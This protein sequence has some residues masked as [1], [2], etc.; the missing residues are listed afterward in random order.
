MNG[1][2]FNDVALR[3][4]LKMTA[5]DVLLAYAVI[6]QKSIGRFGVGPVDASQSDGFAH[7][8]PKTAPQYLE[9]FLQSLITEPTLG[10]VAI[11]SFFIRG[12][13]LFWR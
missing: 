12:Q 4:C 10:A 1:F 13:S 8:F 2:A 7:T 3:Y 5:Q 11:Q 6:V 9:A